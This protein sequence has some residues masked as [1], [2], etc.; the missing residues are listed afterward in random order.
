MMMNAF[1]LVVLVAA[2]ATMVVWA[3]QF[4]V[5]RCVARQARQNGRLWRR[6]ILPHLCAALVGQVGVALLY[7]A[8]ALQAAKPHR[9]SLLVYLIVTREPVLLLAGIA[10]AVWVRLVA[11]VFRE[12][13][14]VSIVRRG[15]VDYVI[16]LCSCAAAVLYVLAV[17]SGARYEYDE[18]LWLLAVVAMFV[19]AA[20]GRLLRVLRPT[21]RRC[22]AHDWTR[23][24]YICCD[25]LTVV[26][27]ALLLTY[28]YVPVRGVGTGVLGW[29]GLLESVMHMVVE[30]L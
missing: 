24:I 1:D 20:A 28:P 8:C 16:V 14:V 25:V 12:S 23:R 26:W 4:V 3:G 7:V 29:S 17:K 18:D 6:K 10:L 19:P 30:A 11:T 9:P 13:G 27:G 15:A 21:G 2:I 5:G 22:L